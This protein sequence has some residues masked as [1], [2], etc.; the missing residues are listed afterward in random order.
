MQ[1]KRDPEFGVPYPY[2]VVVS[3]YPQAAASVSFA[4]VKG[5]RVV[6]LRLREDDHPGILATPAQ[7][8]VGETPPAEREWGNALAGETG[9]IPVFVKRLGKQ[10]YTFVGDHVVLAREATPAELVTARAAAPHTHGV[11][12]IVY[13]KRV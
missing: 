9:R 10:N 11:A 4:I 2:K 8:W 3:F 6:A 13:L 5:P 7:L 1:L 12:R